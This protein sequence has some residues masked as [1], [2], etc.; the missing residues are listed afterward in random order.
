[1]TADGKRKRKEKKREKLEEQKEAYN[2]VT[3]SHEISLKLHLGY[4]LNVH[5]FENCSPC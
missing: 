1:L 5:N 2:Y 3:L 4:F